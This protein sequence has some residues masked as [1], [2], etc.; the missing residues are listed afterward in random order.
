MRLFMAVLA[1]AALPLAGAGAQPHRW[2][3]PTADPQFRDARAQLQVLIDEDAKQRENQFCLVGESGQGYRNVWVQWLTQGRLILWEPQQ[4][5]KAIWESRR[6]LSLTKDVVAGADAGGSTY[7]MTR[8][9][10]NRIIAAC[11][12][13]G[14]RYTIERRTSHAGR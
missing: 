11:Q 2:F 9:D 5:P 4:N 10:V 8:A 3:S 14:V 12:R 13:L 1:A 6:N 7:L